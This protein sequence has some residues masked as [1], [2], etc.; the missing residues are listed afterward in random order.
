MI[1]SKENT[2]NKMKHAACALLALLTCTTAQAASPTATLLKTRASYKSAVTTGKWQ[3]NFCAAKKYATD[4][5]LP[6]IA[7]WSNGDACGHCV[8]FENS[9]NSSTFQKWMKTSGMVFY[10]TYYGDKGDG[11]TKKSG[12]KAD[13]SH[14]GGEIFHWCRKNTQTAYPFVRVYWPAG[15]VDISTVGDKI[16]G[17]KENTTGGKNAVK[18]FKE[19]LAKF[20][21]VPPAPKYTGGDFAVGDSETDRL[22]AEILKTTQVELPLT[23]A[24]AAASSAST[25][26]VVVTYPGSAAPVTN[27][28]I[29]A[30]NETETNLTVTIPALETPDEKIELLLLDAAGKAV[31]TSHVTMVAS[32]ENSPSNPLWVGEKSADELAWGEWTMDLDAALSKVN[33]YNAGTGETTSGNG[34]SL[35]AAASPKDRAYTLVLLEGALWCPDCKNTDDNL[36]LK[37]KFKDWAVENKVALVALDLPSADDTAS[38][39]PCLLTTDKGLSY[40]TMTQSSGASYLSRKMIDQ[41]AAADVLDRNWQIAQKLRLPSASKKNRPPV[42]SVFILRNDGTVAGR[43]E[44][45]GSVKSPTDDSDIDAHI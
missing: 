36:F 44:Y 34:A 24:S 12:S 13:D 16:D 29:W 35:L 17:K 23:R 8:M 15:K 32:P 6:F 3:S 26:T 22:E 28:I 30:A 41:D 10:F 45:F 4:N 14:V 1:L 43:I 21:P 27:T 25:N 33:A 40:Y 31:A 39:A 19:K 2:M 37:Q 11:T 18:W 20:K 9:V 38:T 7:V 42:P 5:K